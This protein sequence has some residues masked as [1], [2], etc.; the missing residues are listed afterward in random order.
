MD[1]KS[2]VFAEGYLDPP[3]PNYAL[4]NMYTQ[5]VNQNYGV[6]SSAGPRVASV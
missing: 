1:V 3:T 6:S 5:I 2:F 4:T